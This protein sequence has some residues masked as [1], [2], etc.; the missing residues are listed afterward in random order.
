MV[1]YAR[2][3]R[4]GSA[5]AII[6][7][8]LIAIGVALGVTTSG[9]T[10]GIPPNFKSIT[11]T[12]PVEHGQLAVFGE[13]PLAQQIVVNASGQVEVIWYV[14]RAYHHGCGRA[15]NRDSDADLQASWDESI[16]ARRHLRLSTG[17]RLHLLD[18]LAGLRW[19][20]D[21]Q[22]QGAVPTSSVAGCDDEYDIAM[23]DRYLFVETANNRFA[24]AAIY[25]A[26]ARRWGNAVCAEN[27]IAVEAALDGAFAAFIKPI[28][29]S[30]YDLSPAIAKQLY[31][32]P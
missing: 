21:W 19:R 27:Q 6:T 7:A 13:C 23:A 11:Y 4:S 16:I 22:S 3:M 9:D 10:G 8:T 18:Q 30:K 2:V 26:E 28:P 5:L 24:L 15:M 20:P 31:R 29:P 17:T 1:S 25:G 32:G 12:R 14:Q